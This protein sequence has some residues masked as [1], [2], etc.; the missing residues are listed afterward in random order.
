MKKLSLIIESIN[1]R[2]VLS[3]CD[4][5]IDNMIQN[6]QSKGYNRTKMVEVI[7][8]IVARMKRKFLE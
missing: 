6:F 1:V 4:K 8:L 5:E 3:L 7:P 2:E